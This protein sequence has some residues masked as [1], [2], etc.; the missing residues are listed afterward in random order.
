MSRLQILLDIINNQLLYLK[1]DYRFYIDKTNTNNNIFRITIF[2]MK[3]RS[4]E[5]INI[6]VMESINRNFENKVY[7]ELIKNIVFSKATNN[8]VVDTNGIPVLS[9]RDIINKATNNE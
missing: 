2:V 4:P 7:N 5:H 6:L 1:S 8:H 3:F 9:F